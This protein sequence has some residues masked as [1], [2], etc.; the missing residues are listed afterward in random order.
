VN[1]WLD[2]ERQPWRH[3]RL[4]WEWVKTADQAIAA[5]ATGRVERASLDHDLGLCGVC[6]NTKDER[7]VA[8]VRE[9]LIRNPGC[10]SYCSC[11]HNG[12]GYDVVCW[13]EEHGV[14]PPKGVEVHSMNPVGRARMQ[15]VIDRHQR[16]LDRWLLERGAQPTGEPR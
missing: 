2:D 4:G 7:K 13:M 1:L 10:A 15:A 14:W 8:L 6:L 11:K 3:G 12:T 9:E 5:L 16:A